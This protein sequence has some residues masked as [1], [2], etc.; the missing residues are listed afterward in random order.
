MPILFQ[1]SIE[2]NSGSVG[3]IAEQIGQVAINNGWESYITYA[4]NH[5]P[6]KSKVIQI[7][8]KWDVYWH[9]IMTRI[10][11]S[12]CLHSTWATKKLIKQI[13]I[14][15]PDIIQLHHIH[16]Y[17]INMELLFYYLSTIDTPI[18]WIFHDCWSMTG[19]CAHFDYVACNKWKTE[20]NKCPQKGEYPKTILFDRSRKNY[21]LKKRLFN[22]PK[23]MTIVPVSFWLEDIVKKSFLKEYP[24]QVIHNGID[25]SVFSP[26][27]NNS[28]AKK[29]IKVDDSSV[30]LL[31]VASTWETRKG[32]KDFIELSYIIPA[33]W[34]I[35]L[36][37]LNENQ[38][39]KMPSNIIGIKRTENI[40]QLACLYSMADVF[41]NPTWEDT[42]PTTNLEAMACGTPIITYNTGGSVEAVSKDTGY[43]VD[44][45]DIL[46][47]LEKTKEIIANGKTS[48][49]IKCRNR[50][51]NLYNK[52][53]SFY[54]YIKL[55]NKLLYR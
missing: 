19:H 53:N 55:Y 20:C 13:D 41:I 18:I 40:R 14:I 42:F 12:H 23:N 27:E 21:G 31:G 52:E 32:L 17:Y 29:L 22:L 8:T 30:V 37:G 9:G 39:K 43:I 51:M 26:Q 50:A 28:L 44:K 5:L 16:G 24:V 48:Y 35:V 54:E 2:V 38:I 11:D 6:S 4:R 7:G 46:G 33:D 1:I 15:K 47:L 3:R 25:I 34:K 45:G 36:V 49:I 10:F